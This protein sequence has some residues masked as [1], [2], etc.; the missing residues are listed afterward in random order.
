MFTQFKRLIIGKPKKNRDLKNEK[1]SNFK[2]LAILSSDALSSVAYGPEQ[3][4][5]TLSM[6]GA[7]ASW[8]TLPIAAAVLVLLAALILSYRQIIY[9]YPKGG[10][11]Y[12]VSKTN[13]GEKWGLLA[14]GS[15]LVDYILTV[16][17]SISSGA[18]A[19]VAAFPALY[20]YKVFIACLLVLFILIMS[21]LR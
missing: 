2:A 19:F 16:A 18:D 5:I 20:H 8:Y 11:A 4:L 13:L 12:M 15:L 14:G 1:I 3:I 21:T 7:I 9:A 10:G 6:V 17:V